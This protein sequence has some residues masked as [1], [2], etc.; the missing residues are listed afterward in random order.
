MTKNLALRIS[1]ILA[2][3]TALFHAI[4]GDTILR[5]L[6]INPPEQ[7]SFVRATHQIG[8]MGWIAG[9]VLLLAAASFTSQRARNWIVGVLAVLYGFPA[10]GNFALNSGRP[11]VGWIALAAV[12]V[13]ALIGRQAPLKMIKEV[14]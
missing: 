2:I 9:G 7:M 13:L 8:T 11:S 5:A 12:V 6:E 3:C 14:Q 10:V 4:D 1:G